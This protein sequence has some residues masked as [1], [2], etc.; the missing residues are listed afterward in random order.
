[1]AHI[2]QRPTLWCTLGK[3]HKGRSPTSW[4]WYRPWLAQVLNFKEP[5]PSLAGPFLACEEELLDKF[6]LNQTENKNGRK[7][8]H[9]TNSWIIFYSFSVICKDALDSGIDLHKVDLQV[10]RHLRWTSLGHTFSA[11][12]AFIWTHLVL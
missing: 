12:G 8:M 9:G 4:V 5:P 3:V 10:K 1:M 2:I 7:R 11:V 6:S